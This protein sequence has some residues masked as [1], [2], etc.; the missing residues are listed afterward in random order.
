MKYIV[1]RAATAALLSLGLL[2]ISCDKKLDIEPE[3]S[4][5]ATT[6]LSDQPG[7][8]TAVTGAYSR[9]YTPGLYG[10]NLILLPDLLASTGYL[11]WQGTFQ[12]YREM[13]QAQIT[14]V[15]AD[16]LRTW[17][18]AYRSINIANLVLEALPRVTFTQTALRDQYEGEML[19]MRGLMHFELVRLYGQPSITSNLGVPVVTKAN[20]TVADASQKLPR[21]TVR[22][23]YDQILSDMNAAATKLPEEAETGRFD[24]YDAKALL[25]RVHLQL[26][27]YARARDLANEVI[28]GSGATLNPS[29][30]DAFTGGG[31]AEVLFEVLQNEQNNAGT[32]NDGLATFYSGKS[33]GF[34]GRADVAVSAAFAGQYGANDKR[35]EQ[36]VIGEGLI[37][38]GD[39]VRANVRR[40]FKWNDPAQDI[41]VIRL[42]EMYLI[43]AEGN[44]RLGTSVGAAP[45]SD[46]NE[47]RLRADAT[48][49]GSVTLNEVLQERDLELAFEGFRIHDYR[50][51]SRTINNVPATDQTRVLPI[52]QY[53]INLNNALPQN[54]GY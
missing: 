38:L 54:P 36:P 29:V 37:Y 30:L 31:S 47:L 17:R 43:R 35:G 21:A 23:V 24:Q 2:T 41:P 22:E 19:L 5:D 42:A 51:T 28:N 39:A 44:A 10:T 3:Q 40:S 16:A 50:R 8:Q 6:A 13:T 46:I 27:E 4:I 34:Q 45:L 48:P 25:A 20:S 52:P 11:A 12:S 1:S 18:E 49:L 7:I 15:N 9:L 14:T 33:V 53:E 32:A 26:G